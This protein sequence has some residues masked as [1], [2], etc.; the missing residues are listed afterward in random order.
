MTL[1]ITPSFRLD[2]Q[3]AFVTGAS[4]GIGRAGAVAL[5]AAGA[6]VVL[7]ARTLPEMEETVAELA[8]AGHRAKAVRLD[9]TDRAA[10]RATI[11]AEGPF[12]VLLNNAGT[13]IR[14]P[15]LE[16]QDASLD[17]LLDLNIRAMF[18]TAQ[19]VAQG[20]VA[21]GK[22]GAIINLSSV[23]GHVAGSNRSVYSATKHAVEGMTKAMAF[24]LG[25][26]GIRVNTLAPGFV[27]T[28]L[29]RPVLVD[30]KFRSRVVR[31][32]PLGRVMTVE[33]VMGAI[34]FLASDASR[35]VTG[36]SLVVDGGHLTH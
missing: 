25:Q 3:R 18:I 7:A 23:N 24:E 19:A 13:N 34:V 21:A 32:M 5:A 9:V 20:M 27:E 36:L 29:T 35:M 17:A 8:A 26:H 6:E 15:F 14:E 11:A 22:G 16:V 28:P 33:D 12:G 10:L 1:P 31:A 30:E 4:K 2:G